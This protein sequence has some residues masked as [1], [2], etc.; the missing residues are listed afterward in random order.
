[1][2]IAGRLQQRRGRRV[3][4]AADVDQ[5]QNR[6][7]ALTSSRAELRAQSLLGPLCAA[8]VLRDRRRGDQGWMTPRQGRVS[9]VLVLVEVTPQGPSCAR[10]QQSRVRPENRALTLDKWGP[11]EPRP[12]SP[13]LP[14][15][16]CQAPLAVTSQTRGFCDTKVALSVASA[17]DPPAARAQVAS[18][19]RG[20]VLVSACPPP[21]CL[22][23]VP[24]IPAV[25]SEPQLQ[26]P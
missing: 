18:D 23:S 19:R 16:A 13:Q 12:E 2:K 14:W 24:R 5:Q 9:F 20:R 6:K 22:L 7:H 21:A 11:A 8:A 26:S 15:A 10:S 25:S 3:L 17:S 4:G 1:M